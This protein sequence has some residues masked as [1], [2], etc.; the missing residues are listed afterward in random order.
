METTDQESKI[1]TPQLEAMLRAKYDQQQ[2]ALFFNVPDVC[3]IHQKR[4]IDALAFG[5]WQSNGQNIEGFELKVSRSD[6]LRE[7]KQVS[8]ADPFIKLCDHFWLVTADA[9]IAKM[10]EIPACW[11]WMSATKSGLR[12]QRPAT[13]LPGCGNDIPRDF[14]LGVMRKMQDF[15]TDSPEVQA[16][17]ADRIK[18]VEA[19]LKSRFQFDIERAEKRSQDLEKAI[20]EF[21]QLSGVRLGTWRFGRIGEI[22]ESLAS[23]GYG[24]GIGHVPDVLKDQEDKLTSLLSKVSEARQACERYVAERSNGNES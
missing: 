23:L 3:S 24:K 13:K 14:M 15:S 9:T 8:K 5:L 2:Y 12:I 17:I 4:R 11:G 21:E 7:V 20:S 16:M 19:N 6:W 18:I 1:T 22:V 10:E